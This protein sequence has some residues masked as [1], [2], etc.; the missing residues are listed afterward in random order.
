MTVFFV[1]ITCDSGFEKSVIAELKTV[2]FVK[3]VIQIW[4]SYDILVKLEGENSNDLKN[5]ITL[6]I[7]NIPHIK[8]T[9]T[10]SV[11]ESQE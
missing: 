6:K 3:E 11:L 4:G 7:R 10:L 8:T 1:L 5:I 9:V 2:N